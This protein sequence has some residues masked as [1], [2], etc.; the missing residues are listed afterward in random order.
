M[1]DYYKILGVSRNSSPEE[2]KKAYRKLAVKH[3]PDKS[4][5]EDK[6]KEIA[7]AYEILSDPAKKSK[8]DNP[9]PF[10]GGSNPFEDL[11]RDAFR[12]AN[13]FQSGDFSS[14]FNGKREAYEPMI[15]KGR[16][17]NAYVSITL[18]EMMKGAVKRIKVN[19][20]VICDPCKGTGAHNAEISNCPNCG[21]LGRVNKTVHHSF[22]EVVM[23]EVCGTCKGAGSIPKVHCRHCSGTGT[24]KKEEEIDV[25]IPKGSI[26]GVSY[27]VVGK[28][29]WAKMPSNPGDLVVII[30]EYV[31]PVYVRDGINLIHNKFLTFKEAC[32]GSDLELPDLKGS[33]LRIRVPPGTSPG[34]TL[35]L[36]SKGL[37]EFNGFG[38]GDILV[39]IHI[40]I[41]ENL[42]EEQI[43]ALDYFD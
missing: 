3:H 31:H 13:P 12:G 24:V 23:Q 5:S 2:I 28:G 9:N 19:R 10:S 41:P 34:K 27:L 40:M 11:F 8:Y 1:K 32:L 15:N 21:G 14:F 4:G 37:P 16:N 6:F 29:D 42:T 39:K 17:I 33:L 25:S 38:T 22:G 35:R 36:H 30:E 18:E 43:K 20:R 7:E 26:S